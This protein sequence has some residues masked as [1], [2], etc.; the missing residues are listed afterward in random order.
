MTFFG[1]SLAKSEL[2]VNYGGLLYKI[3][4]PPNPN[5]NLSRDLIHSTSFSTCGHL[6]EDLVSLE[7]K[8][9]FS[10]W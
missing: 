2:E 6:G 9:S 8:I 10:V 7:E 4:S 1:F 5:F 3:C